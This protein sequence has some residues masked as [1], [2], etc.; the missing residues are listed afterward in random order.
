M[1]MA[2]TL[3]EASAASINSAFLSV[4][5]RPAASHADM[6]SKPQPDAP[7]IPASPSSPLAINADATPLDE[8]NR[9]PSQL[10]WRSP[11]NSTEYELNSRVKTLKT[12]PVI[13][14]SKNPEVFRVPRKLSSP[15]G[16]F[17]V[18]PYSIPRQPANMSPSIEDV[19]RDNEGLTKAIEIL[20]DKES[21]VSR[22]H[23][24]YSQ[25]TNTEI[26][27]KTDADDESTIDDTVIS[28]FSSFSSAPDMTMFSKIRQSPMKN[29][30]LTST[31]RRTPM[32]STLNRRSMP[33]NSY[34]KNRDDGHTTNLLEF[35]EQLYGFTD[36]PSP[37]KLARYSV[38]LQ[39]SKYLDMNMVSTPSV[40]R[41]AMSN[42]IDFDIPPA[43]TPR[44]L[45][46]ITPRELES[47]KSGFLSEISNLKASLSGKD[48][49]VLSLKAA[50]KDAEKRVG[51]SLEQIRE[52]QGQRDQLTADK[53]EWERRGR[54]MEAMLR[55][56]REEIVHSERE[57][58]ELEGRLEE[59]D[60]RRQAA[61]LMAQEAE[62]KI[63]AMRA[64][65]SLSECEMR[66]EDRASNEKSVEIAVSKVS[67][68]LHAL[69]K[70]KHETKVAAL[71]K[72]YER[73][74]NKRVK[75]LECQL[76]NLLH[77]KEK[78]KSDRSTTY[79]DAE[80]RTN[81]ALERQAEQESKT[82]E[83]EA[84]V[85]GLTEVVK[86]VTH[87]NSQLHKLLDH[88][89]DEKEKLVQTV[90]EMVPLIASFDDL[91]AK[92]DTDATTTTT[93]TAAA[94]RMS[95]PA[96]GPARASGL[97]A[98]TGHTSFGET[99]I[100]KGGISISSSHESS[101]SRSISTLARPAS[102][103]GYKSGIMSSIEKMGGCKGRG[104]R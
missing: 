90:E 97:R 6:S 43:P 98:P 24:S 10:Q 72:S 29:P 7:E 102:G 92:I 86:S 55:N 15:D 85:K 63:A 27:S 38:A 13:S 35:S 5:Q 78:S 47:L 19:L 83:L 1:G 69:Y 9:S 16:R 21:E 39:N 28:T 76:E 50:V 62:S 73:R 75:E 45:P 40:N 91:L 79:Q 88:E 41:H 103:L 74:W 53:E 11:T 33:V 22:E 3:T 18:K 14:P 81:Q 58:E 66:P 31:P 30:D 94:K 65:K 48:A 4:A 101:R 104:D 54:E 99:R 96:V 25:A 44:S 26:P 68:D 77:E 12:R 49:E 82:K 93:S 32:S 20:E 59:S 80:T 56:V 52:E 61:E 23:R 95:S 60:A 67:R 89:R 70:E 87:D 46:T 42:L 57:R 36:R 34:M 51:E 84:E 2:N 100:G 8:E 64:G 37:A 71:K 17:P